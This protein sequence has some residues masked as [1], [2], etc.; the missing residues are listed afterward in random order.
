MLVLLLPTSA[1][2]VAA[3]ALRF[4]PPAVVGPSNTTLISPTDIAADFGAGTLA[5]PL[6][7]P[8]LLAVSEDSSTSWKTTTAPG[9][10]AQS[11]RCRHDATSSRRRGVGRLLV[12]KPGLQ[13]QHTT[14]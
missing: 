9:T 5:V 3:S 11:P 10:T 1:V 7:T 2:A 6:G 14:G 8:Q 4:S 12:A 13:W